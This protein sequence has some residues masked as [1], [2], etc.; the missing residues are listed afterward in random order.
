MA[1]SSFSINSEMSH[2]RRR[3]GESRNNPLD[4]H[5]H[6]VS[7]TATASRRYAVAPE[8]AAQRVSLSHV[9]WQLV[10]ESA[11]FKAEKRGFAPGFET[12]DWLDAERETQLAME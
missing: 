10:A 2:E 3:S 4:T 1:F 5:M 12:Q 9:F 8:A 6:A 7:A 11:Y